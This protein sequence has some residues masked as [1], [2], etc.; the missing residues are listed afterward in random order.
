MAVGLVH[1]AAEQALRCNHY[2]DG[3][4][5][6]C[7]FVVAVYIL[8]FNVCLLVCVYSNVCGHC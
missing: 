8:E 3:L 1:A 2:S 6:G 7:V 4:F 5:S